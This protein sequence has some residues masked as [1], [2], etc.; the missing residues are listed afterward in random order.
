M[1]IKCCRG[2]SRPTTKIMLKTREQKEAGYA[3]MRARN[4]KEAKKAK[5]K[6]VAAKEQAAKDSAVLITCR[7]S[8]ELEARLRRL[9]YHH[10][11]PAS[12]IMR[13]GLILALP[14]FETTQ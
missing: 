2:S 4:T 12:E 14:E 9:R 1:Y 3:E 10:R 11:I 6:V 13:R 7:I 8:E 5:E